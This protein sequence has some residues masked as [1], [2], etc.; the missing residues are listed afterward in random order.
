MFRACWRTFP[1]GEEHRPAWS[2]GGRQ[3]DNGRFDAGWHQQ[4]FVFRDQY[5]AA[6]ITG[7]QA[8]GKSVEKSVAEY[9]YWTATAFSRISTTL[10]KCLCQIRKGFRRRFLL[11]QAIE[12]NPKLAKAYCSQGVEF[13]SMAQPHEAMSDLD[14]AFSS[15]P[16]RPRHISTWGCCTLDRN[17]MRKPLP[18]SPKPI[19]LSRYFRR[20]LKAGET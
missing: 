18:T 1:V 16:N 14:K 12:F 17:K 7:V 15:I 3:D 4:I 9:R 5:A 2:V 20:R 10:W 6:G 11:F 13:L 19:E 8:E